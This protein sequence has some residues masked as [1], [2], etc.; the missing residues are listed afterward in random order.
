[1]AYEGLFVKTAAAFEK[2]GETLFAN[3][4]RLRDLLSTGGESTNPTTLAEYQAV[5]SEISILRNA[6]SSTV[7]TL[8]DIDATIVANF[9]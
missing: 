4:I 8:K 7:K 2:A 9:R 6:Q 3:E 5:I 1:M